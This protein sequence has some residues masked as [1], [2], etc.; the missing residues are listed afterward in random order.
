MNREEIRVV[1]DLNIRLIVA[2]ETDDIFN[3]I[4]E[5]Q[6]SVGDSER[7]TQRI[8]LYSEFEL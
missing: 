5:I 4:L 6:Q 8:L 7:E 1:G 3:P 2:T